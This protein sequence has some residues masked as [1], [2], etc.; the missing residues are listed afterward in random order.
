MVVLSLAFIFLLENQ[1]S[2]RFSWISFVQ[3]RLTPVVMIIEWIVNPPTR[4]L[5]FSDIPKWLIFP[6]LYFVWAMIRGVFIDGWYPYRFLDPSFAGGYVG[7]F[8]YFV[9]LLAGGISVSGVVVFLGNKLKE[10]R[11]GAE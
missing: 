7:V 3:H 2:V 6:I 10:L 4:K 11:N 9:G 8:K 1:V 5:N